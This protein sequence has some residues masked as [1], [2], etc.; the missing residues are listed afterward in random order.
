MSGLHHRE[1]ENN[2]SF[3]FV[4]FFLSCYTIYF[5]A[6]LAA[7]AALIKGEMFSLSEMF[8][9]A[10]CFIRRATVNGWLPMTAA[11]RGVIPSILCD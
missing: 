8:G 4:N 5:L 9:S 2:V 11:M 1:L 10:P 7:S 6:H 3:S